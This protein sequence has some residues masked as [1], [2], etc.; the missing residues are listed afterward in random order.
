MPAPENK[1]DSALRGLSLGGLNPAPSDPSQP[2]A[3]SSAVGFRL[4]AEHPQSPQPAARRLTRRASWP[5]PGSRARGLPSRHSP[6]KSPRRPIFCTFF[7]KKR[8]KRRKPRLRSLIPCENIRASHHDQMPVTTHAPCR[9]Q[10]RGRA[11][12]G[13]SGMGPAL[14]GLLSRCRRPRRAFRGAPLLQ[15]TLRA[16]ERR[17]DLR[18]PRAPS[19]SQRQRDPLPM[20]KSRGLRLPGQPAQSQP[21]TPQ[22]VSFGGFVVEKGPYRLLRQAVRAVEA[23]ARRGCA[24]SS[25][26]RLARP[27][28]A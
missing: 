16:A 14:L 21:P 17:P 2:T 24:A 5:R 19:Y 1:S 10:Q 28:A 25:H 23:G 6:K 7:E 15:R 4:A 13:A 3:E 18:S 11:E 20:L 22:S 12:A 8:K 26:N 9:S 27:R